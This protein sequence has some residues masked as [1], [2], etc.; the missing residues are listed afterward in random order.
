MY[1][2]L[3]TCTYDN[4]YTHRWARPFSLFSLF[5]NEL[6]P[7]IFSP[8]NGQ[9]TNFRLHGEQTARKFTWASIFPFEMAAYIH[10]RKT[11]LREKATTVCLL[12]IENGSGKLLFLCRKQKRKK[13]VVFLSRQM[14]NGD[15]RLLFQRTCPS[16]LIL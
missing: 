3:R 9:T 7:F 1:C 5:A 14:I 8:T 16:M 12:K 13:K 4:A 10:I 2:I 6:L 15:R 11:E